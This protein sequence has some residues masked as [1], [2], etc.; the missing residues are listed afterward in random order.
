MILNNKKN[1]IMLVEKDIIFRIIKIGY[2]VHLP[3]V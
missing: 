3:R 2:L 1:T